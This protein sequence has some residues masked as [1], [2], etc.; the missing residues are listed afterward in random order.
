MLNVG[1]MLQQKLLHDVILTVV[2]YLGL[3]HKG[4]LHG[5]EKEG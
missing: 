4:C 1:E 5:R 2:T 3:I